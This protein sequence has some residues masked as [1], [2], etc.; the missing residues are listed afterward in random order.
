MEISE[1]I[2]QG[3]GP[4]VDF[5]RDLSSPGKV[6]KDIVA[7]ANTSGGIVIIGVD[8][9][10]TIVGIEDPLKAEETLA[11]VIN[12]LIDP[13]LLPDIYVTTHED[14][15]LLVVAVSHH[16]GPFWL[17]K[18]GSRTLTPESG[19]FVR[20]GSTSR[21]AGPEILA[22]LRRQA[23]GKPFDEEP[24]ADVT[25][26]D[27]DHDRLRAAL[28]PVDVPVAEEKLE[29]L[30][31]LTEYQGHVVA[32]NAGV[33]L[34][35]TDRLRRRLF[36]DARVEAARFGGTTRAADI[37]DLFEGEELTILQAI[38]QV[39]RFIA[40]NT[41]RAEPI[42][43]GEL[44]RDQLPEYGPTMIRELL[45]NAIAHADYAASGETVKVYIFDD[46]IELYSPGLMLPGMT[47]EELKNG[48]SKI[49][50]RAIA[51]VFRKL[52]LMERFGTAWSKIQTELIDGYPEPALDGS[53]AVFK[54]TLWP[55]PNFATSPDTSPLRQSGEV[56]GEVNGELAMIPGRG[57]VQRRRRRVLEAVGAG[58]RL[59]RDDL[60]KAADITARTLDRDIEALTAADLMKLEGSPKIGGYR[61]TDAGRR[62]LGQ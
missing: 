50:N 1:L 10:R 49:R 43:R 2:A 3:E 30:G 59:K 31:I 39:E 17:K 33:I 37:D 46:R 47:V 4:T 5:K 32:T 60:M 35:G 55:H 15:E 62:A 27:L 6:L 51:T 21:A 38:E 23:V 20:L 58:D 48:R 13:Q 42:R 44:R 28:A 41:R 57:E 52:R 25:L 26:A 7:F 56:N 29:A 24:R 14:K 54:A 45:V 36:A 11:N 18:L 12:D 16:P 61:L 19:T 34:F 40:R 22:E 53:A 9:D 8:D